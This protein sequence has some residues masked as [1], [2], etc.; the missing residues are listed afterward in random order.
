[1]GI[2]S[3]IID[4]KQVEAGCNAALKW[5]NEHFAGKQVIVLGIL[6]GC[7]PFLGKLISQF[8]FDLQLDF[9]AVASYHGGSRQQE[10]PKIVLDMSHDPKGKDILLIEDII[11]SGRSIKLVLDLLHTRKAKS[12]IL[13]SFIEKLK[14]REVDIKV[15]YS[16]FKNQDEF[17]VGFGLDYQGFYRNLPYVG[18]F[19]PEDN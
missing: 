5:C 11:D 14:P 8:T 18:V 17:L 10:A 9:V 3:I 1:M 15:D 6:K 4:Q 7:I 19:D 2:K 16:C 13:V 12:V